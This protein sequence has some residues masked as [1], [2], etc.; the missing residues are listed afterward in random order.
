LAERI[1]EIGATALEAKGVRVGDV[2]T[3]HIHLALELLNAT[4]A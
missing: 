3:D 2:V 1:F 4:D